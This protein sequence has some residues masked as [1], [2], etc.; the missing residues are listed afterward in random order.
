MFT[1]PIIGEGKYIDSYL[2]FASYYLTPK[3]QS[4]IIN[5]LKLIQM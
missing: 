4:E 5:V 2:E 3:S 1:T